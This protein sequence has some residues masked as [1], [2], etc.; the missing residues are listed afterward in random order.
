MES[1]YEELV[2]EGILVRAPK[3]K[4]REYSG[5]YRYKEHAVNTLILNWKFTLS[6]VSY[7]NDRKK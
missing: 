2:H 1:L 4:L 6:F 5:E 3:T 7:R